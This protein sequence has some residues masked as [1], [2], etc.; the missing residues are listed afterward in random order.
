MSEEKKDVEV[1]A[2]FKSLVEEVEKMSVLDLSELVKVLEEKFGVSAAAP[3][4]M[5]AAPAVGGGEAGGESAE[6][7]EFTVEL[8][9]AGGTKIAV[10][11]VVKELTGLGLADAKTLVD[12]APK[13][14]KENV[15]KAEAEE[16]KKKIEEAGG[17]VVLK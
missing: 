14:V 5:M 3:M 7:T 1:P 13:V 9:E 10:I 17:K 16:M 2:K 4:A 15:A 8:T 11:K 12:S 6:K